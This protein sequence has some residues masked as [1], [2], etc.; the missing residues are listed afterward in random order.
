MDV[1][2]LVSAVLGTAGVEDAG[3]QHQLVVELMKKERGVLPGAGIGSIPYAVQAGAQGRATDQRPHSC[4]DMLAMR[5]RWTVG[6]WAEG[7]AHVATMEVVDRDKVYVWII[8]RDG[9]QVTLEDE[10]GLF[11]SDTLITKIRMMQKE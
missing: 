6:K 8:S 1:A 4:N 2:L 5:M 9:V 7:F 11:P 3:E 10:S